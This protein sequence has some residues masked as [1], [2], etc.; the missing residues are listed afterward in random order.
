VQGIRK[1][2]RSLAILAF[3]G[4]SL[5]LLVDA[6]VNGAG[7]YQLLVAAPAAFRRA[8]LITVVRPRGPP[9][10]LANGG[11]GLSGTASSAGD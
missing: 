6:A 5:W 11:L 9:L 3:V 8:G 4:L 10:K 7:E 2:L 1:I